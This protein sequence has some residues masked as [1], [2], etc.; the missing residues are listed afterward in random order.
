MKPEQC[1]ELKRLFEA[2]AVKESVAALQEVLTKGAVSKTATPET[3][4]ENLNM[5]W[6]LD[7]LISSINSNIG[8]ITNE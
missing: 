7:K 8:N 1:H 4:S 3:R 5:L 6:A 2:K